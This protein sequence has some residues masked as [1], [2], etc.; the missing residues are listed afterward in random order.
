LSVAT[1]VIAALGLAGFVVAGDWNGLLRYG[2]VLVLIGV[3]AFAMFWLPS[4][5]VAEHEV[6][7]RNV[8]TTVHVPWPTIQNV[9]TKYALTLYTSEGKVT[10]WA[11]PAPNR[12]ATASGTAG[13]AR[14]AAQASGTSP[15]PGD[16]P[17][18]QSGAVAYVIRRH[19]QDLNEQGMLAAGAEPGSVRRDIHWLTAGVLVALT[20]ASVLGFV[21]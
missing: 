15:R 16:L 3:A 19:W 1:A 12:Y 13:D 9:D 8:F 11:S 4:V 18:T 2:W 7:V 21:L 5:S 20:A 14:I 10:A 17:G 6:T